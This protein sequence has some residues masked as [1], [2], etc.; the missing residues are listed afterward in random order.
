MHQFPDTG[1]HP[2]DH[3]FG[4]AIVDHEA[5]S[6]EHLTLKRG[7]L[8]EDITYVSRGDCVARYRSRKGTFVSGRK[9]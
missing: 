7:M 2:H 6:V 8:I 3:Q 4:I 5:E 1:R 9:G